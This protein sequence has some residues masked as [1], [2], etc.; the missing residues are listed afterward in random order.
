MLQTASGTRVGHIIS[1][2]EVFFLSFTKDSEGEEA[3]GILQVKDKGLADGW[4]RSAYQEDPTPFLEQLE[5]SNPRVSE[6][7]AG[8]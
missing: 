8:L 5:A 3:M 7:I 6:F 4:D 2:G 1:E